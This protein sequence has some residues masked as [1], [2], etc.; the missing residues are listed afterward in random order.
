M[1]KNKIMGIM[2]GIIGV[3][4]LG[5]GIYIA[6]SYVGAIA[7]ATIDFV[8]TN[9]GAISRCGM[10]IPDEITQLKDQLATTILPGVYLGIP[11]AVIMISVIM[12][13]GGY[14]FGRGS[15]QEQIDTHKRREEEVEKEVQSRISKKKL[16][17]P[18]EEPEAEEGNEEE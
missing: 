3:V 5:G 12:F 10:S 18:I 2:L 15:F 4:L 1:N 14:F 9:S 8:T 7:N 11:L 13:A 6:L 16:K 17:P